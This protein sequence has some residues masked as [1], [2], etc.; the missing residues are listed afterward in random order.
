MALTIGIRLI[1]DGSMDFSNSVNVD[2]FLLPALLTGSFLLHKSVSSRGDPRS[3]F[4]V[5]LYY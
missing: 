5:F 2:S 4:V 1:I 3:Q